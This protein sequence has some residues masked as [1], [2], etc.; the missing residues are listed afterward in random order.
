MAPTVVECEW[1]DCQYV[2]KEFE[3][4]VAMEQLKLH[5][6][7]KH[8]QTRGGSTDE[9]SRNKV[10]FRQPKVDLGQS[11]EEWETFLTMR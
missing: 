1:D 7:A 3:P 8:T 2:T 11:L 10:K 9:D 6:Q 5:T 4:A